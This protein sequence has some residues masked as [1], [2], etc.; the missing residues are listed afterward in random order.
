MI[1]ARPDPAKRRVFRWGGKVSGKVSVTGEETLPAEAGDGSRQG[2]RCQRR[3]VAGKVAITDALVKTSFPKRAL[4]DC[5]Y[6]SHADRAR[7]EF[8]IGSENL[9]KPDKPAREAFPPTACW[10]QA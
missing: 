7:E 1:D 3:M 2:S 10:E 8:P 4:S 9:Q 6:R 5:H